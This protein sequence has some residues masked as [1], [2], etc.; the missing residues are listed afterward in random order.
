M[1]ERRRPFRRGRGPRPS[2][3]RATEPYGD[4][5]P[6]RDPVDSA[7]QDT[8]SFDAPR[9]RSDMNGDGNDEGNIP[10]SPVDTPPPPAEAPEGM[11]SPVYNNQPQQQ[12]RP[13][14][15]GGQGGNRHD[16][17]NRRDRGRGRNQRGRGRNN[18]RNQRGDQGPR[19]PMAPV[20]PDS[21]TTGWY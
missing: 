1:N 11:A 21:E 17:D 15:Y 16:R 3:P 18:N 2:G 5:D 14:Q 19:Q 9:S 4:A 10:S 13:H 7:P 20:V 12:Q 8:E 6:Y